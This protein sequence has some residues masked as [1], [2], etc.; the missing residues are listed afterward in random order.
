MSALKPGAEIKKF[1]ERNVHVLPVEGLAPELQDVNLL[2]KVAEILW[3]SGLVQVDVKKRTFGMHQLLQMA[4]GEELEWQLQFERMKMLLQARCGQFGDERCIDYRLYSVKR[5]IL[6]AAVA[7]VDRMRKAVFG[8]GEAWQSGMLL[9]LYDE[10]QEVFGVG[11][12]FSEHVFDNARGSLTSDLVFEFAMT[13][14]C[15]AEGRAMMLKDII[16]MPG[17][18]EVAEDYKSDLRQCLLN[19]WSLD[20]LVSLILHLVYAFVMNDTTSRIIPMQSIVT[21]PLIQDVLSLLDN[22]DLISC[23]Q[24]ESKKGNKVWLV[25]E[26]SGSSVRVV[27]DSLF[28]KHQWAESGVDRR[29]RAMRWRFQTLFGSALSHDQLKREILHLNATGMEPIGSWEARVALGA[30]YHSIGCCYNRLEEVEKEISAFELA[31]RERLDTLGEQH[32]DTGHAY[33]S[34]SVPYQRIGNFDFEL[35]LTMRAQRIFVNVLGPHPDTANAISNVGISYQNKKKYQLAIDFHQEALQ[36]H[37]NTAGNA[38]PLSADALYHMSTAFYRMDN[39]DRALGLRREVLDIREKTLGTEHDDTI[40]ARKGVH[41]ICEKL[42]R[43]S[44]TTAKPVNGQGVFEYINGTYDGEWSGGKR[45]GRGVMYFSFCNVLNMFHLNHGT[46]HRQQLQPL[47]H[48]RTGQEFV[49]LSLADS[50]ILL[51]YSPT[52]VTPN[53]GYLGPASAGPAAV[54]NA[55]I[56]A[57]STAASIGAAAPSRDEFAGGLPSAN[58]PSS[59]FQ[60][61]GL[62]AVADVA[63][64]FCVPSHDDDDGSSVVSKVV[65]SSPPDFREKDLDSFMTAPS[66]AASIG[67]AAP[68]RDEFAGGLPSANLPSSFFQTDGLDAVADVADHFCVPSHD[69]DDGSSV[70]SKVVASSPPDFREKDLDS[71]MTAPSTAAS[72]GAAAPSR[73][74]FAGG[75][76]SANLPSSFFQTDGLDAVADVADHF[77]VPSHDDDDGSSVVSKVVASSPPDFREKDFDSFENLCDA[78]AAFSGLHSSQI[79]DRHGSSKP[80]PPA[81]LRAMFPNA[82]VPLRSGYLYC[83]CKQPQRDS[84]VDCTWR[85]TYKLFRNGR[86]KVTDKCN[87]THNHYVSMRSNIPT[88]NQQVNRS[89]PILNPWNYDDE[90]ELELE[91]NW[92]TKKE[93]KRRNKF[94]YSDYV[95]SPPMSRTLENSSPPM[96][97]TLENSTGDIRNCDYIKSYEGEW[98]SDMMHGRANV[99]FCSGNEYYGSFRYGR[100]NGEG[101]F[102]WSNRDTY[103]GQITDSGFNGCGVFV[104]ASDGP[105]FGCESGV[106]GCKGDRYDGG[107]LDGLRHGACT[108]TFG[109][110]E[111]FHCTWH[112]GRCPE[113]EARMSAFLAGNTWNGRGRITY[114]DG[115][116]YEGDVSEG[117]RHGDGRMTFKNGH[118]YNG[119]WYHGQRHGNGRMTFKNGHVYDGAWYHGQRHGNGRMTFKNDDVYD[120]AWDCDVPSG[121]GVFVQ[122]SDGPAFG[123]ESGVKGCKGDRYDGGWLDG[124]RHGACTYTFGNGEEFHCTWHHGRAWNG[125]GRIKDDDGNLYEGDIREGQRHGNGCMTFKNGHVYNGAWY[126]GQ[127]HG[128]GRMTFKNDDVYDGAWDCDV[129]SGH[130]VFVQASDGPAFGC[131]SGVKGCKGDRYDGG[132]L[133]GLR[134]GACTYTFGNGEEFH[135]TWHHGRCPE[136]EARMS[137]FLVGNTWNGRGRITYDDDYLY[138][139]EGDIREGQRHGNGRMTFKNDD[140]Y[141]GA[142]DC[143]VPS[144][145]GVFV[146]ASDGPAF[147]CESGVTGFEGDR[148]DGGWLDGLR[149]GACTYTFGN[150]EE[151]HCT[152]HHGRA[153]NGR[154][155]IKDDDGNL[156]EGDIREGQRHGNG[157]MTFKNDDV[158]DGAWDCDVPSGHGVFVQ[159][160]DGPAFGCESGV[161]GFEGD[162]YDGGWLDGL[163]HGACTYTFGNGEEFHCTWHHGRAWNGRGRIK[164]DDGNL[165]EGDIR[166]GQRHGNGC[167]TFKNDDVYDGAWDCDVPSG[168]GVFVQASDGPAFGCESGV[169]GFEGDLYD[170]GWLDGLRHGACTYTFGNGEEFHCTWHHGRAWNGRGRIKDDDGNL[171]EGDIREGQRHGNG[172]MTFKND[173]VYDG[174]WDCDVPSGH[175]VFV[176]A[177]DGPAFGCESGVTGF[178][179]DRYDGG[180]LD[181]LRH[182]ACTYT[183]GN[184]EQFL[185]TWNFGSCSDEF[186]TAMLH[187]VIV[188][189]GNTWNGRGRITYDDDYLYVY[190]GDI[191]EGQRHGN[192]RMTFKNDDVYDGAWDC[193]VPSGHGVFVQASDG[194]AFGCESGVTGFEGDRYDGS[195]L[196]GL[197][198]GACT[199]TFGNGEEFHC[200]WHHG[201]AWNGRGRIKDDDGNLYEGD[202]REGQRHG[203]GCMTFKNGHVYNGAWYHGQRHGNGRMTFKNDDVYDGAWDCDVPSGHGVFVQASDGP[204]FGCESGVTGFEGDRYDGGWLDGLRHGACTYTFGNGEEFHC[205]WHHGRAWNGRGRIKDD[206]GNLYEGDIRE[207]QRHGNGRMTFINSDVYDGEWYHDQRHGFGNHRW[208]NGDFYQGAFCYN[209]RIGRGRMQLGSTSYDGE[210]GRHTRTEESCMQGI[211]R[212]VFSGGDYLEG[213]FINH[214]LSGSGKYVDVNNHSYEAT[215]DGRRCNVLFSDGKRFR[216]EMNVFGTF[217][218]SNQNIYEGDVK[219]GMMHGWGKFE[220]SNGDTYE[221][222]MQ[223]D[224]IN[225]R[226]IFKAVADGAAIGS[227][228]RVNRG[229]KYVGWWKDGLRHGACTYTF[230]NG[231]EF[232][233]TWN[234]GSCPEFEARQKLLSTACRKKPAK[235][236]A[237]AVISSLRGIGVVFERAWHDGF[238]WIQRKGC[239]IAYVYDGSGAFDVG[240]QPGYRILEV[241]ERNVENEEDLDEVT[242][243]L[244][245]KQG[246]LVELLV[247]ICDD[248]GKWTR[249]KRLAERNSDVLDQ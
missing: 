223:K 228:H 41:E 90:E 195:W 198:H 11:T 82:E 227:V 116:L 103:D 111:E 208:T 147:G 7:I 43:S 146:Q 140:V 21:V 95:R 40:A 144:G 115:D 171:Y 14:G 152:W 53:A 233:C 215:F 30:A 86:W 57:P 169:T 15:S 50:E 229:D 219:D 240:L 84:S 125:R 153:W 245:G 180:W 16:E 56:T 39:I 162:R 114:D 44:L 6:A 4:V 230:G 191:R 148:Y 190:E 121:H 27:E 87:W 17:V 214:K 143:D 98:N 108:Y 137:A 83:K 1:D 58:L 25:V 182:G 139:Y 168:H 184:G 9:R 120:G 238:D 34:L 239:Y 185:C 26:D 5:E 64:H 76:P 132:W 89:N 200:T 74:E 213:R 154:G 134:H 136:F 48:M 189:R 65:A 130:G 149:H 158:Y 118:V 232:H 205:T 241:N 72:I 113:F 10:A 178:E 179:G 19:H 122:A 131:E 29:L 67:A 46:K 156:Y 202:I 8:H 150:G 225:G 59:F 33:A 249:V 167:M 206:D 196:D 187:L 247:G 88:R 3:T 77:C 210:W 217:K 62:D 166:E 159:A 128:N 151:F 222:E 220:W 49:E 119:A 66:T 20:S 32:P 248:A 69:D 172:R 192:G 155:R 80:L 123:C 2:T 100:I 201:R 12:E 127:R 173:D 203:N 161:T 104:Q 71:F 129:P 13:K 96:S 107:W 170:G 94:G 176:Q 141:D 244:L 207:G 38:H 55:L 23:L 117:Q 163:R 106:K 209:E 35:A 135:C 212:Q 133:D 79:G 237:A 109:N 112:H 218:W 165:Y 75:L 193:D 231:E 145:H 174:A 78:V 177:S 211:G 236:K 52:A 31:L 73:D 235:P 81:W 221:G 216:G 93:K 60:T 37:E 181:G 242:R 92:C 204:A 102:V 91:L 28:Q 194:P 42:E 97:R 243:L 99:K 51:N 101:K 63:D 226:G 22:F 142:W 197:R 157:R 175:G 224:S 126:H 164:D 85:V 47:K 70:V 160:S 24:Y 186:R 138:V 54:F 183:F 61:D 68:S 18:K 45:Q 188:R 110:G 105:A 246:T 124:L 234:H 36:M 199:Y